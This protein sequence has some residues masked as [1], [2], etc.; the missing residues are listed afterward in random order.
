MAS[1]TPLVQALIDSVMILAPRGWTTVELGL[2]RTTRGLAVTEL[3]TRGEGSTA[4]KPKPELHIDPRAEAQRLAECVEELVASLSK[5]WEPGRLVVQRTPEFADVRLLNADRTAVFFTRLTKDHLDPLLMTDELFELLHGAE[6]AFHDLQLGLEEALRRTVGFAFDGSTSELSLTQAGGGALR[7]PAQVIGQYF[8]DTFTWAWGWA[9]EQEHPETVARVRHVCAP[10]VV[11]PGLSA[12]WRP[13]F[14]CDEGFAW[15][16]AGSIVVSL[17][18]RGV[19]RAELPDHAGAIFF[20]VMAPPARS[21][22]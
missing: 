3:E 11:Q 7:A 21:P 22:P 17:G 8:A 5:P 13:E 20:A 2:T 18:A 19:F 16:I 15:A 4:P 14:H 9:H 10:E 12:L 1:L 6:R